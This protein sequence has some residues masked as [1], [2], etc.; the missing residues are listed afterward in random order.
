VDA[1]KNFN[2]FLAQEGPRRRLLDLVIDGRHIAIDAQS[3]RKYRFW[4][5]SK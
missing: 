2:K 4:P 5:E 1:N 3:S